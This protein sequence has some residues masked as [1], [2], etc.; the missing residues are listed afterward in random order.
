MSNLFIVESPAKAKTIE[1]YLGKKF[2]VMASMGHIRDLP[3]SDFGI[4]TENNFTP[5][6]ITIRGKSELIRSLKKEAQKADMVYLA[7]DPDREGEAISWHL[8]T[9]LGLEP[10]QCKR[11]V[12]NEITKSALQ[13]AVAHPTEINMN[14]VD[15]QQARRVLDRIVGYKLSPFLWKKVKKGL[16]AGRVQSV[17]TAMIVDREEEIRAFVPKEYWNISA[18][19]NQKNSTGKIDAK[20]YGTTDGAIEIHTEDEAA[21]LY[22]ELENGTYFI[23]DI[24]RAEKKKSPAP[25][26]TTSTL[27][28]EASRRY[29][30]QA[31]RTMKAAQELY[32]GVNVNGIGLI[33]LITYMR[34]DSLRISDEAAAAAKNHIIEAF[35]AEYYP[36]SRRYFKT[37]KSAQDAHEAIRP[38]NI[39][40]T[41][42][43][44]KQSCT[45]EQYRIYKLIYD[46]FLASQMAEAVYDTLT[47]EISEGKYIFKS[48]CQ[49]VKFKGFTAAYQETEDKEKNQRRLYKVEIGEELTMS[50]LEK[51]QNFTQPPSRYTEASLIKA[52]EENEIGRPSTFV[53]IITTILAREYVEREGK[54]LK[55]TTLGEVTTQLM[56]E[57]FASIVDYDF[58]AH[59]ETELD[60]VEEGSAE[61][62]TI[63]EN[64]YNLFMKTL[65][66]A[67]KSL[68][69]R[70]KIPEE[71]TE[72]ICPNCGKNLVIKSGRYGKFMACPGYP[73]CR[74]TKTIVIDTQV[75]CPKCGG[76]I[77]QKKS[78]TGKTYYGCEHNPKC[79]FMTWDEPLTKKCEKCGAPLFKRSG[80][81]RGIYCSNSECGK[82][83]TKNE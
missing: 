7:T 18:V 24:K 28:Q 14:L 12:F 21:K 50:S 80:R 8:S 73:D 39:E 52:L 20:F 17:A 74:F 13:N 9:L 35:G 42:D 58:T 38:T 43:Q 3:K 76:K 63:V 77:L 65:D 55:P 82:Q 47:V 78:K 2:K 29:N 15:A 19:F 25:P 37:K 23:R 51:E 22:S 79:D 26:F 72:E 61:W 67:E 10:G 40:I 49:V 41:P 83:E 27:Q 16:S 4:D 48:S 33:G 36:P 62:Q 44:V 1:K 68:T 71:V 60:K 6:Y 11:V 32:E 59:L 66:A 5:K 30:F 57:H 53:P 56:K 69:E 70:V 45:S 75:P 64:Y 34:T 46:R 31:K 81:G 54:T